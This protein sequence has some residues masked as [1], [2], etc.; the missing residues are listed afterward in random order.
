M[1][2]MSPRALRTMG[3]KGWGYA[4]GRVSGLWARHVD[5]AGFG[6]GR[7]SLVLIWYRTAAWTGLINTGQVRYDALPRRSR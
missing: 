5:C 1:I 2:K 4:E 3:L 6:N 7:R